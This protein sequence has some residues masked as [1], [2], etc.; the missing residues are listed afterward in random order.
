[1]IYS[2]QRVRRGLGCNY[3]VGCHI[4]FIY[5]YI[6]LSGF[7][8]LNTFYV[9]GRRVS[10]IIISNM[11]FSSRQSFWSYSWAKE[12]DC[13]LFSFFDKRLVLSPSC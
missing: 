1:M 9:L 11:F 4:V 6:L 10:S 5:Y 13:I 8:F 7:L 12:L 2:V 3:I